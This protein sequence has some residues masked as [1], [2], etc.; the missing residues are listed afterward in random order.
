MMIV[1]DIAIDEFGQT[2][3][4][5][6]DLIGIPAQAD[7]A[8]HVEPGWMKERPSYCVAMAWIICRLVLFVI[9]NIDQ[10]VPGGAERA[11]ADQVA[12]LEDWR[13][14]V[15]TRLGQGRKFRAVM[16]L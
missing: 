4:D 9:A 13:R 5:H 8:E 10:D 14:V 1:S 3:F 2:L 12:G 7:H 16:G 11:V 6:A 15:R